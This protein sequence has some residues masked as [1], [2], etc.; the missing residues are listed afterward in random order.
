MKTLL[1]KYWVQILVA[2]VILV[3]YTIVLLSVGKSRTKA[4][5]QLLS[6]QYEVKLKEQEKRLS[7]LKVEYNGAQ[8]KATE[9]IYKLEILTYKYDSITNVLKTKKRLPSRNNY[10]NISSDSL[11]KLWAKHAK[12]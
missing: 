7:A 2:S 5:L 12:R 11:S 10:S 8:E 6:E 4:E 9:S 1:K 3:G